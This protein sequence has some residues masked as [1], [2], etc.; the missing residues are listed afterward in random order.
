MAMLE[1]TKEMTSECIT[2]ENE[3]FNYKDQLKKTQ[4]GFADLKVRF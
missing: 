2:I 4:K 1:E 3:I